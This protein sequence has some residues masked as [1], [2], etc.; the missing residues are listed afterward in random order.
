MGWR[1]HDRSGSVVKS[2]GVAF[3]TP[4]EGIT[5][6]TDQSID[7]RSVTTG[8][9]DGVLFDVDCEDDTK[10]DFNT[11]VLARTV[12]VGTLKLGPVSVDAGGVDMKVIFEMEPVGVGQ[13]ARV[14]FKDENAP[15]GTQPYWIRV[16]Q[17]DGAKAWVSPFYVEVS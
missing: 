11:S 7:W 6:V 16:T 14:T 4:A 9:A 10:I 15:K 17:T 5:A 8:D 1:T 3:D 12:T 13:E 2:L